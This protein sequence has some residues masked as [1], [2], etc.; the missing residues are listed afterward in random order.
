MRAEKTEAFLCKWKHCK[1]EADRA[2]V[3]TEA[4]ETTQDFDEL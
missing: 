2:A 3:L 4:R 1:A